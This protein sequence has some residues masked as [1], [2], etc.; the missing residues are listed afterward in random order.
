MIRIGRSETEVLLVV[1]PRHFPAN[2]ASADAQIRTG[3]AKPLDGIHGFA[4]VARL[5]GERT[6][7]LDGKASPGGIVVP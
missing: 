3:N 1:L 4:G 6:R 5:C 2:Q 7:T